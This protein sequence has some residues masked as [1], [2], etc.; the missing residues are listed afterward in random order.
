MTPLN[1]KAGFGAT[2]VVVGV[3]LRALWARLPGWNP[4]SLWNDDLVWGAIVRGQDLQTVVTVPAHAP[5]G[6]LAAL[7]G[8]RAAF[9]DPEWSLQL[10]PFVCGIVAIPVMA[11]LVQR[12]TRDNALAILAACLTAL[13][14][15]L[16][17]YTV[18]VKQY[19]L[20]FLATA[21]LLLWATLLFEGTRA[22][23]GRI[24]GVSLVGGLG[25]FVSFTS[26]FASAPVV[27]LGAVRH[28]WLQ[29]TN[30][31]QLRSILAAATTYG[32]CLLAAY[33]SLQN[34]SNDLVRS[35]FGAGFIE[36]ST[37]PS[38]WAFLSRQGR[39][40]VE[41]SL[42]S[43]VETDI[44]Q[45]ET[46]SWV[47]PIVGLGL[48]WL[49]IRR[50]TR[51]FGL[52]VVGFYTAFLLASALR[53]YPLGV[54]RTNIFAF[55][56]AI[57]LF[58]AGVHALTAWIPRAATVRMA[59]AV[60]VAAF[61]LYQPVRAS[62]WGVN[63]DLLIEWLSHMSSPGDGLILSPNGTYL[64]A[65]YG[66]WPVE[67]SST[68]M[69]SN[70]TRATIKRDR[71]VHLPHDMPPGPSVEGFLEESRSARIWYLAFRTGDRDTVLEILS[72]NG[73]ESDEV[74]RSSI[75]R[76]YLALDR[77]G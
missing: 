46:M 50:T 24:W 9:R 57:C 6:F 31:R 38:T 29:G 42:P 23:P 75:G 3:T 14:P 53:I 21:L 1:R 66:D 37:V 60:A 77:E 27:I 22:R 74:A 33:V 65:Y 54:D 32:A 28:A 15:L 67:I 61:A 62:Y 34:R 63:D 8:L 41:S 25:I 2:L 52:V 30:G 45:P 35:D 43:W 26:V 7:W 59:V 40:L 16:A 49:L 17:H 68:N 12:L 10:L 18:F 48:V 13:N 36:L 51:M 56:A 5:P 64:A 76:L 58:A 71:T 47:L 39:R 73:Y 44:W 19:S 20:G 55:P 70:A 72:T 69:N 4:E 11:M